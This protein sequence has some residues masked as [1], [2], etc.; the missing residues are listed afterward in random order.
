MKKFERTRNL[1]FWHDGSIISN[2]SRILVM[3]SCLYDPAISLTDEEYSK[4]NGVLANLQAIVGNLFLY[5]LARSPTTDQQLLYSDKRL[6]D[7]SFI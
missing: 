5:I 1:M 6:G 3:V 2:H 7:T 4:S